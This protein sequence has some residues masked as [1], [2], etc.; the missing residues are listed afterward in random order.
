MKVKKLAKRLDKRKKVR[1]Y[2]GDS[3]DTVDAEELLQKYGKMK[4][5]IVS[6]S[7]YPAISATPIIVIYV[8]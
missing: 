5:Q 2:F 3:W 1:I 8:E 4:V 6:S 7:Y